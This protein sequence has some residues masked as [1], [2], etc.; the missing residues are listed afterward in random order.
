MRTN[1]GQK[2]KR[3]RKRGRTGLMSCFN[4]LK[5]VQIPAVSHLWAT[6][7]WMTESL[8]QCSVLLVRV[9]SVLRGSRC[10]CGR[11]SAQPPALSWTP[12]C[13]RWLTSWNDFLKELIE[14]KFKKKKKKKKKLVCALAAS[15]ETA[16]WQPSSADILRG[17]KK[18]Y[19]KAGV[20]QPSLLARCMNRAVL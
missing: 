15:A 9:P 2:V 20:Q 7:S 10:V 5:Q 17:I 16:R 14:V 18:S 19:I 12:V 8:H 1:I 4:K 13:G 6:V 11:F 3:L